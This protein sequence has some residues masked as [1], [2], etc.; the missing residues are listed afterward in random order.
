MMTDRSVNAPLVKLYFANRFNWTD[1]SEQDIKS[2]P[3]TIN[4]VRPDGAD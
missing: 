2:E 4:I 3:I 1:K